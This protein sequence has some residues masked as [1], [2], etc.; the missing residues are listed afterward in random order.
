MQNNSGEYEHELI[1]HADSMPSP[2]HR[3]LGG[4]GQ[5]PCWEPGTQF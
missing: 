4:T 2:F 1:S 3:S 5:T